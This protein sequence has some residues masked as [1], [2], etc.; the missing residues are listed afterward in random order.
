MNEVVLKWI[1]KANE[2]LL[3]VEKE[4]K[5]EDALNN[6][7]AFHLQQFVEKYLKAFLISK[8]VKPEKTHNID[9]LLNKCKEMDNDFIVFFE[10]T[11]PELTDCA[12]QVRYPDVDFSVDMEFNKEVLKIVYSLKKLIEKKLGITTPKQK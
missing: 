10:S 2:D 12:I 5:T 8:K 7:I 3:L 4:I 6:L 11:L 1:K 9:I